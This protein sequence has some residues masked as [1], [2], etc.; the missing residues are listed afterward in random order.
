[1]DGCA[2]KKPAVGSG[3]LNRTVPLVG[4]LLNEDYAAA[5]LHAQN[6]ADHPSV[7]PLLEKWQ[8]QQTHDD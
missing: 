2:G 4:H 7:K 6:Y 1:M 8:A 3:W 5:A